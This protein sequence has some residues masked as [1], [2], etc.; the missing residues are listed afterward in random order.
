MLL[1]V[2]LCDG[3]LVDDSFSEAFALQWDY[4]L[5]VP[6]HGFVCSALL[7]SLFRIV[8]KGLA[9]LLILLM[10]L[11]LILIE[12]LFIILWSLLFTGKQV[13]GRVKNLLPMLLTT[14]LMYGKGG[15]GGGG[16]GRE[17]GGGGGLNQVIFLLLFFVVVFFS[18]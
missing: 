9:I 14:F 17:V 16:E 15:G 18:G 13:L 8:L 10:Q 3:G 5:Y 2:G 1:C 4:V 7:F 6:L 11:L 12:V